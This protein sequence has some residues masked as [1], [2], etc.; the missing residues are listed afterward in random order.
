MTDDITH[1]D[2]IEAYAGAMSY[3]PG[4][5]AE[6]HVSC[7][8][9][10]YDVEVHRWGAERVLVWA[11][12]GLP[13]QRRSTPGDA[14][15][16][17]CDWPVSFTVPVGESWQSGMYHVT[18]TARGAP[19]GR[20]V[21]HAMFVVRAGSVRQRS[22]LVL[23]T[24][25][26]MAYNT[27][28]GKSLYT[29][30]YEV[31]FRR[32]FGR[33]MIIRPET[34]RDDR[35]SRPARWGEKPDVEGEIYQRYRFEH[36]Y[37]GFMGSTGWFTY[38]RR[39][40]EWAER[41]G[42]AFDIAT[43]SDL[44]LHSNVL[45]GYS[46]VIGVGHD[47]YWSAAG[48]DAVDAHVRAGGHYASFS[49]N[50]MFWQVRPS[51][52]H[53][54]MVCHKYAAHR[55][56]PVMGTPEEVSMTGMWS[57]PVVHRPET[58]FLGA[59]SAWGL[60]HRFGQATPRSSGGF[61]V[62]RDQ[63]WLFAGTGLRYG[64]VLGAKHGVVGYETVGCRLGLDE[65]QLPVAAG[66]DGTP[67]DI[68]VVAFSPSSNLA[69]GEYP[70]SIAA[71]DDQGDIEFVAERLFGRVDEDS[72]AR[73]RHGNAVI[74]TCR[75]FGATGGEVVTIGSTDWVF[76]LADDPAVAQVTDNVLRRFAT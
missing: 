50:T 18:L 33:G 17:G 32:P 14:D 59:G 39:F 42:H 19:V 31:S 45:D 34:E 53:D 76:G 56:D 55:V 64:D 72:L 15:A 75:P 35:K 69:K 24:N 38:E 60:Y 74:V 11:V 28:G 9:D 16:H 62:Y 8:T 5:S 52:G 29:G 27:W 4:H 54:S 65:Y 12:Q 13:G 20:G 21:G 66:G 67:A 41:A 6:V 49:G 43:S 36:G 26:Y 57:D 73:C 51:V 3:V 22:L 7:E 40:V 48:R 23:A 71:L 61:T 44:D 70:A 37:P 58:A 30:G 46:L 1:F 63:H 47:E 10:L 68:E 25:T 2:A